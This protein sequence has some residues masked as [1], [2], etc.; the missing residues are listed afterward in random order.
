[1]IEPARI[2]RHP[3]VL[4]ALAPFIGEAD[5]KAF[6]ERN[7]FDLRETTGAL[8]AG[9]DLGTLFLLEAD[10]RDDAVERRFRGRLLR[11][12]TSAKP[13]PD[14]IR[15]QGVVGEMPQTLVRARGQLIALAEGDP[16]LAR[17]VEGFLLRRFR[18]TPTA[19]AGAAL[20]DH[21]DFA[22]GAPLRLWIPSPQQN[23]S[24]LLS[25]FADLTETLPG[26]TAFLAG[27]DLFEE[28]PCACRP[29]A[30]GGP[31]LRLRIAAA[32]P[33]DP[34]RISPEPLGAL[35][36]A[37]AMSPPG[38]LLHLDAPLR[39]P[40]LTI[41]PLP[42]GARLEV[43]VDLALTPL[44]HG[45]HELLAGELAEIFSHPKA[46]SSPRPEGVPLS[47]GGGAP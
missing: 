30:P 20:R 27:A 45:L 34:N 9:F 43:T 36:D 24:E 23:A 31:A 28:K 29:G 25:P 21:A 3:G 39:P 16:S 19:L 35:W 5:W 32:G 8:V 22:A 11:G 2:A 33:W 41:T 10:G 40:Q 17:I 47:S 18:K 12:H 44:L 14:V 15:V 42:E 7:G 46:S 13:H 38:R 1:M 4:P 26:T 37:L 6:H